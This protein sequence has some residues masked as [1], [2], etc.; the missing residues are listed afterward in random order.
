MLGSLAECLWFKAYHKDPMKLLAAV[1]VIARFKL[2]RIRFGAHSHDCWQPLDPAPSLVMWLLASLRSLLAVLWGYQSFD[3]QAYPWG[4][5]L[6]EN[7]LSG[8][9]RVTE[10]ERQRQ[11]EARW[12]PQYF[13]Y[14]ILE[15]T[16]HHLC[17]T[18]FFKS[19]SFIPAT[20]KKRGLYKAMRTKR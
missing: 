3:M 20:L 8:V 2:G 19:K 16:S 18:L 6:C 7:L 4:S 12:K 11:R 5:S 10:T 13:C 15:V 1:A 17:F 9:E 14:L